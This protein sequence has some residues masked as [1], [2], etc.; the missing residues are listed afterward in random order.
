MP[1][2]ATDVALDRRQARSQ[3]HIR[4]LFEPLLLVLPLSCL[5]LKDRCWENC[6]R[7]GAD[8]AHQ[9]CTLD[10]LACPAIL[11]L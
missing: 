7:C 8:H 4:N 6:C 1:E 3:F 9:I 11:S 2:G 5:L 10:S